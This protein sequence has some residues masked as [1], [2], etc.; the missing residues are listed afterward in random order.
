[1]SFKVEVY[2][3]GIN[4]VILDE[5]NPVYVVP[6]I[7]VVNYRYAADEFGSWKYSPSGAKWGQWVSFELRFQ[8][9]LTGMTP[10]LLMVKSNHAEAVSHTYEYSYSVGAGPWPT[11][12]EWWP[13]G[14]PGAWAGCYV[15][16]RSNSYPRS[17]TFKLPDM[18]DHFIAVGYGVEPRPGEYGV[19]IRDADGRIVFNS[20][21][22]TF[23]GVGCSTN[24]VYMGRV[25]YGSGGYTERYRLPE[26]VPSDCY[27]LVVPTQRY[28]RY[29]GEYGYVGMYTYSGYTGMYIHGGRSGTPVL[30][31]MLWGKPIKPVEYW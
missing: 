6:P 5:S 20:N 11:T 17:S 8:F 13:L 30:V 28:R 15:R 12:F 27:C 23:L 26:Q 21:S 10:P 2:N 24:W 7:R 29:N 14:S 4:R 1:M 25:G 19:W 31:P 18:S 16:F 22:N 9:P 3:P